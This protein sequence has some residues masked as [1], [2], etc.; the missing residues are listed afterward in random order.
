MAVLGSRRFALILIALALAFP[1][2]LALANLAF[3]PYAILGTSPLPAETTRNDRFLTYEAYTRERARVDAIV[4]GA[5]RVGCAFARE[6][7]ERAVPGARFARLWGAASNPVEQLQMLRAVLRDRGHGAPPLR[8]IILQLDLDNLGFDSGDRTVAARLH[9]EVTGQARIAFFIEALFAASWRQMALKYRVNAAAGFAAP[10][11]PCERAPGLRGGPPQPAMR[12]VVSRRPAFAAQMAA[13]A[14]IVALARDHAVRL[15]VMTAPLHPWRAAELD[16][17][18]L[19]RT[20]ARL[21]AIT[22]LWHFAAPPWL[23][24]DPALWVDPSHYV[25]A[26]GRLM[27]A[28]ALNQPGIEVPADFGVMLGP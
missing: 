20:L 12:E 22:P 8:L 3:D 25:R 11:S 17:A 15:V 13:V 21:S 28:R 18:D 6:D 4:L 1:W 7:L 14:Q 5:S 26:V 19:A 27:I 10:A 2:T 24:G 16:A 9:P 23:A